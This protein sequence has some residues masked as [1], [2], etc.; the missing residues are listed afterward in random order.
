MNTENTQ[1]AMIQSIVSAWGLESF[2]PQQQDEMIAQLT[3]LV[4][5]AV[6]LKAMDMISSKDQAELDALMDKHST[7]A[8]KVMEFFAVRIPDFNAVIQKEVMSIKERTVD[9]V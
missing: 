1:A 3:E 8:T 9:L 4:Y 7:D 5:Q 2:P 6:V